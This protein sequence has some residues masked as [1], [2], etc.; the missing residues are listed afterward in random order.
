MSLPWQQLYQAALV[1]VRPEQLGQRIA[2]AEEAM[3]Q[4]LEELRPSDP[5]SSAERQTIADAL[6]G[7]RVLADSEG[8]LPTGDPN[9]LAS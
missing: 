9:K 5:G 8:T 3:E 2:A 4:R 6:R 1:E 7:L